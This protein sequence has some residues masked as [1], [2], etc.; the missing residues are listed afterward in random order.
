[1][2]PDATYRGIPLIDVAR[3]YGL[4]DHTRIHA[5]SSR[6]NALQL[7][8]AAAVLVVFDHFH[9]LAVPAKF[10]DCTQMYATLLLFGPPDGAL[11]EA[12]RRVG[13]AVCSASDSA[14]IDAVL[15]VAY[16]RWRSYAFETPADVHGIFARQRQSRRML[17][18]LDL[19]TDPGRNGDSAKHGS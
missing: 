13:A 18:V 6:R 2:G 14:P 12:A 4:A 11:A 19:V 5:R 1:M 7:Q 16:E 3:E 8:Q 15:D 17:K 10:Y 9:G